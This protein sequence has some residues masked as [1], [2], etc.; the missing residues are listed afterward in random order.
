MYVLD[1]YVCSSYVGIYYVKNSELGYLGYL[2]IKLFLETCPI[3]RIWPIFCFFATTRRS[4]QALSVLFVRHKFIALP[5]F[6]TYR[7]RRTALYMYSLRQLSTV[8]I[9]TH[10]DSDQ[11]V[12]GLFQITEY[13][14]GWART[15]HIRITVS[16]EWNGFYRTVLRLRVYGNE[17]L[18]QFYAV[19]KY[20]WTLVSIFIAP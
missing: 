9:G 17:H 14:T 5:S 7:P 6:A 2:Q 1:P 8:R 19:V 20:F 4:S 13:S 18:L 10:H 11:M 16:L 12:L 15:V 3:L